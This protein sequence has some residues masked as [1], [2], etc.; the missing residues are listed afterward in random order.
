M[1][2]TGSAW[3]LAHALRELSSALLLQ[4]RNNPV[5]PTLLW[6]Y[7]SGG[8][9][10]RTAAGGLWLTATLILFLVVWRAISRRSGL[11]RMR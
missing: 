10:N 7:W 9:P 6:D 2:L 1:A 11:E 3:V 5:I 8:E 4:G